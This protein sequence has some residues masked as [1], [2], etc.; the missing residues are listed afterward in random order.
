MFDASQEK[1]DQARYAGG[2]KCSRQGGSVRAY[3]FQNIIFFHHA[4][5]NAQGSSCF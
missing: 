2:E 3:C 4:I 1:E 5:L